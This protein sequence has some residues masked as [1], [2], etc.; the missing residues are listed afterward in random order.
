M[1]EQY[2][3]Q[4]TSKNGNYV[5]QAI[6]ASNILDAQ[7]KASRIVRRKRIGLAWVQSKTGRRLPV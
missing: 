2:M 7:E 4:Y 5:I 3:L 1:R 6:Y